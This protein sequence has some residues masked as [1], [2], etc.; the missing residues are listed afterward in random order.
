MG[1][2][3]DVWE[4]ILSNTNLSYTLSYSSLKSED[5]ITIEYYD[6]IE[7]Y[8]ISK[9]KSKY[10]VHF[11]YYQSNRKKLI[12]RKLT[13]K[14]AGKKTRNL[15]HARQEDLTDEELKRRFERMKQK[16]QYIKNFEL[17]TKKACN[18]L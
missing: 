18:N 1:E 12:E 10:C 9:S 6:E 15:L 2:Y 16:A 14:R 7:K 5:Q 4:K 8:I 11:L 13:K 3:L 17:L